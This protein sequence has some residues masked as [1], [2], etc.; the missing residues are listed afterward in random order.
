VPG[1]KSPGTNPSV[2]HPEVIMSNVVVAVPAST[3]D[4]IAG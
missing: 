3:R 2:S 1:E 4:L